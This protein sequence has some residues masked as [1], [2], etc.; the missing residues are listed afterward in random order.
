MTKFTELCNPYKNLKLIKKGALGEVYSA[1]NPKGQRVAIKRLLPHFT[2][3]RPQRNRLRREA[4]ILGLAQWRG[5]PKLIEA[6]LED[7]DTFLIMEWIEGETLSNFFQKFDNQKIREKMAIKFLASILSSLEYLQ[8]LKGPKGK[9]PGLIHSDI[10]PNNLLI[11]PDG[12]VK[13]F[14]FSCAIWVEEGKKATGGTWGYMTFSQI[15]E[16]RVNFQTDLFSAGLVF[17]EALT[18]KPLLSGNTTFSIFKSLYYLDPEKA[19]KEISQ[20]PLIQKVLRQLFLSIKEPSRNPTQ[21]ILGELK[22]VT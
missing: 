9:V 19:S 10:C 3:D 1:E 8:S 14:D 21:E 20:N 7:E 16:G 15:E 22:Q 4:E 11:S 12:S 2:Y 5:F 18:G 17:V 13:L 6:K